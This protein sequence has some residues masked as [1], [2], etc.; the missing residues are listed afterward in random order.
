MLY[1]GFNLGVEYRYAVPLH[2][3]KKE[4]E[5][6]KRHRLLREASYGWVHGGWG[7]CNV[8]CGGGKKERIFK[9]H[10][11]PLV[12]NLSEN[13]VFVKTK[14]MIRNFQFTSSMDHKNKILRSST[15][16]TVIR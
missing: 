6:A 2:D 16:T 15:A 7:E 1:Y 5:D 13:P 10:L 4:K 12:G 14:D 11:I 9:I 3:N 8:H